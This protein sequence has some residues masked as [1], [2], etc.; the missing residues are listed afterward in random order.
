MFG[1]CLVFG[2]FLLFACLDR[3]CLCLL[4]VVYFCLFCLRMLRLLLV[5]LVL[6]LLANLICVALLFWFIDFAVRFC[7]V[8]LLVVVCYCCNFAIAVGL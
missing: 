3:L 4:G 1:V 2:D 7:F 6:D 5:C 8:L